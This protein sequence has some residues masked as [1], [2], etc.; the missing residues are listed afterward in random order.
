[1]KFYRETEFQ[2]TEIGKIPKDWKTAKLGE[3]CEKIKAGGTPLTTKKEYWNGNIP[4]VKIEDMTSSGKYLMKTSSS[5]TNTGLE[6]SSAWLVPENSLLLAMYGSLGEVSINTI[7]VAT[8]QAILAIIPKEKND[9]EFLYYWF[10]Y[11]KPRW[12]KYA[13]P[14]TQANLTA[15]IVRNSTI[16]LPSPQERIKIAEILSTV[17]KT[18]EDVDKTINRLERLKKALMGELLAGRIRVKEVDDKL[19]FYRETEFQETEIGKI[20][21][22]WKTAKLKDVAV[23]IKSGFASGKRDEIDGIIHLRMF[24]IGLD[25]TLLFDKIVKVPRPKDWRQYVLKN[26]DIV[27]VNTSGSEEHIGKVAFFENIELECTYSNHL[28]RI[29]INENRIDSRWVYFELYYLWQTGYFNTIIHQQAGG[30]RNL[31]LKAIENLPI[32]L[33]TI[34]ES[35]KI[36]Y[37]LSIFNTMIK[38]YRKEK[39]EIDHLKRSLMNLLLTGKI[40]VRED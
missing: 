6:N 9:V 20:P 12:R 3:I 36:A 14:T 31:P 29:R 17:D 38:L 27:L 37:I 18:I 13:K 1:M 8:S 5:I 11:F 15:E 34:D 22:D 39:V 16:P 35:R 10:L 30:Q 25:G 28:T 24:N 19:T 7:K 40:R 32:A 23:E 33:P 26:G 21:K 2:E 4:F